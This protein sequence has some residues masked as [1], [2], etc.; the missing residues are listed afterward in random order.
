MKNNQKIYLLKEDNK[1]L[2]NNLL[3]ENTLKNNS[4]KKLKNIK[5]IYN[6]I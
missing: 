3:N 1:Y 6:N 4:E 2:V 5:I